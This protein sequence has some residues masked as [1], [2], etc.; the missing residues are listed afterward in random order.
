M[1]GENQSI[2]LL[3]ILNNTAFAEVT[4]PYNCFINATNKLIAVA[5]SF[6]TQWAGRSVPLRKEY[7][8]LYDIE[9]LKMVNHLDVLK[10]PIN[11]VAF[12][13][14]ES[15]IVLGIGS[16]DGGAF[17]EGELLLWDF[18]SSKLEKLLEDDREVIECAFTEEGSKLRF[19]LNPTDDLYGET[20][21]LITTYEVPFPISHTLK[22]DTLSPIA[23]M[24]FQETFNPTAFQERTQSVISFLQTL[25][26]QKGQ[27]FENR[28]LIWDLQFL[29]ENTLCVAGN[30][31][32]VELHNIISNE[33]TTITLPAPGCRKNWLLQ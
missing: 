11:D 7:L 31:A 26:E 13:P 17:Y 28:N 29:D 9:T 1:L 27:V 19:T 23:E 24:P 30:N 14:T 12:H 20:P 22:V 8:H 16:Y 32:T 5:S 15:L 18:K 21:Y 2:S 6:Y 33:K 3:S 10:Y 25:A 4:R